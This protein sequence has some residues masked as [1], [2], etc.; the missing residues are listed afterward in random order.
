MI[1][2]VPREIQEGEAVRSVGLRPIDVEVLRGQNREEFCDDC[3]DAI[4]HKV[5]VETQAGAAAGFRDADYRTAGAEIVTSAQE[6]YARAGLIVKVA[7]PQPTEYKLLRP[8]QIVFATFDFA[9]NHGLRAACLGSGL[10]CFG[11]HTAAA[12]FLPRDDAGG[13]Q[14]FEADL[15]LAVRRVADSGWRTALSEDSPLHFALLIAE[16]TVANAALAKQVQ[17]RDVL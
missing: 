8:G 3:S 9:T 5:L 16:G 15:L 13:G 1:V 11:R 10:T 17:A 2:G 6:I 7:A 4:R 14:S 12:A